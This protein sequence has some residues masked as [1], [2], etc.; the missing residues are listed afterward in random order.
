MGPIPFHSSS[1]DSS[2]ARSAWVTTLSMPCEIMFRWSHAGLNMC[3][4]RP[5]Y[6]W[7]SFWLLL[8]GARCWM[9]S[10]HLSV[11]YPRSVSSPPIAT[12]LST[13][14]QA[15]GCIWL[16]TYGSRPSHIAFISR[17]NRMYTIAGTLRWWQYFWHCST[18]VLR[19]F[20]MS[21]WAHCIM[22]SWVSSCQSQ[23]GHSL[24]R[25]C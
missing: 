13:A 11:R 16:F 22:W 15:A 10:N 24:E 1:S 19:V 17:R 23:H 7:L 14:A 21:V 25:F 5:N 6:R 18:A 3:C 2:C 12:W 20:C 8:P 4:H 9:A